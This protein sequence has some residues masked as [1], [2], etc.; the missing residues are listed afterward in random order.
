VLIISHACQVITKKKSWT[1]L[2]SACQAFMCMAYMRCFACI[3]Q[4]SCRTGLQQHAPQSCHPQA[5]LGSPLRIWPTAC[6]PP[7]TCA[8]SCR[9]IACLGCACTART[10]ADCTHDSCMYTG[11][12]EHTC[13]QVR[14]CIACLGCACTARTA[15]GCTHDSCMH[16]G[17]IEDVIK[18]RR[19]CIACLGCACVAASCIYTSCIQLDLVEGTCEQNC[20]CIA[21]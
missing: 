6:P 10:A 1:C 3:P 20:M 14:K 7:S 19:M 15:A 18:Q 13:E 9:C 4:P 8:Q 2:V 12:I 21:C 11:H 17:Q 5:P 16:T